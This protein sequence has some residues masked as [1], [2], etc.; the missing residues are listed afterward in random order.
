MRLK[1]FHPLVLLGSA[2]VALLTCQ[3][4][5]HQNRAASSIASSFSSTIVVSAFA[6]PSFSTRLRRNLVL[7]PDP[8]SFVSKNTICATPAAL[9]K[10]RSAAIR[11]FG[12]N[13]EDD[14]T[15]TE[16]I[17]DDK[18]ADK[19]DI[20]HLLNPE[21]G[22]PLEPRIYPQRWV[23]LIYLSL[24]ALI[25]DWIC[26]SVAASPDTYEEAFRHSASSLIDIFLFTNVASCFLVTDV[27]DRFGLQRSVQAAA[28]LMATG[29][30]L[31]S[32]VQILPQMVAATSSMST[33]SALPLVPYPIIVLGT[34]FVGMA[35][36]FFQCTPPLL[37]AKWFAA[38]ERATS[39]AVALNF[40]QI[41]IATAFLV[42]GAMATTV[43]GLQVYFG[44]IAVLCTAVTIGTILQFQ[45]EP[46]IPPSASEMEKKLAGEKE[47]PF[48][49][50]VQKFFQTPG[51][52]NAF[53]AFICSISI[54]NI[55]GAF[56]DEILTRGG[57][58]NQLQIDLAGAG[59]EMAILIGGILIGGYV[60]RTKQYKGVTQACLGTTAALVIPLG[61]T[62][63]EVGPEPILLVFSLLGLGLAAGPVQ[64]IN[65]ELAV[66]VTY[67]GDETAVESVQQ[68][69]GNLVS[70][71]LI[72][73]AELASKRDF[74]ILPQD[75]IVAA[76]IRGDVVLL[77]ALAT[78]TLGYFSTFN[79]PLARTMA[80]EEE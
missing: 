40:N 70:A 72:P 13:S 39:T 65:A 63:H 35:Q 71:V 67:P 28:V 80:D 79:A 49:E 21:T 3:D 2:L 36:P 41:G 48:L 32:G 37:S 7:K 14:T 15:S 27:V 53:V 31:R 18:D 55:V 9:A 22:L 74:T 47:P 11:L 56:I 77:F 78:I 12:S 1:R 4:D 57:M 6:P 62:G 64:P 66:D 50:S 44:W 33:A 59:F 46:L 42:G 25:S 17:S 38:S 19:K 16:N 45:D 75:S 60:D 43:P 23:Q 52:T 54:T 5:H 24:L 8:T 26:F 30:W 34:V 58:E 76:D 51:F 73:I 69:G 29:C 20:S 61:L 68:I 10:S